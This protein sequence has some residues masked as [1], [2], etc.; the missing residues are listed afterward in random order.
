MC[1]Y[2]YL[3]VTV[4]TFFVPC[5]AVQVPLYIVIVLLQFLALL[6]CSRLLLTSFPASLSVVNTELQKRNSPLLQNNLLTLLQT[7]QSVTPQQAANSSHRYAHATF[8]LSPLDSHLLLPYLPLL[9]ALKAS[10]LIVNPQLLITS[11]THVMILGQTGVF[12]QSVV[13]D[14]VCNP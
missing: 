3:K 9:R 8:L 1:V 10:H 12:V 2:L 6:R 11:L 4:F 14:C 7:A 5:S 13:R